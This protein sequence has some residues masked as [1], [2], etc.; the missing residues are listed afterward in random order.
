MTDLSHFYFAQNIIAI[1]YNEK[2]LAKQEDKKGEVAVPTKH[3]LALY[4]LPGRLDYRFVFIQHSA[5]GKDT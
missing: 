3:S 2:S 4:K 1:R 5:D